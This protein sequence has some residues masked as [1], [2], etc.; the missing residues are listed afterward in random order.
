M[1]CKMVCE[2][3]MSTLGPVTFGKKEEQI[4]LGRKICQHRDFSEETA[5]K[6]DQEVRCFV[7]EGYQSA[8]NI[9]K[10]NR[11]ILERI[12]KPSVAPERPAHA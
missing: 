12:A 2:S 9:L 4:F 11:L 7:D 6:I 8:T 5:Q 1:A 10:N 3:G